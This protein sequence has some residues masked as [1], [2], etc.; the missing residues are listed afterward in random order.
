[1]VH[2]NVHTKSNGDWIIDFDQGNQKLDKQ[3]QLLA[4]H[5]ITVLQ[6]GRISCTVLACGCIFT[7]EWA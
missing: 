2:V 7:A 1:M 5:H 6:N 4:A 3:D